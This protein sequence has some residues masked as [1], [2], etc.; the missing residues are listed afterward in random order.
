MANTLADL[1]DNDK[2]TI[3]DALI[4]YAIKIDGIA[5]Q[6]TTGQAVSDWQRRAG[7]VRAL[8]AKVL[9]DFG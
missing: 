7:E 1:T 6:A 5:K 3:L 4:D 9:E 8:A 2:A